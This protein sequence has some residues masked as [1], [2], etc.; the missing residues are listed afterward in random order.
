LPSSQT[1]WSPFRHRV[2]AVLWVATLLSNVGTWMHEVGAGWLMTTM[3]T[4]PIWVALVQTTSTLPVF[5]LALP[6]GALAD[7]LDRRRLLLATQVTM[8]LLAAALGGTVLAGAMMPLT[9][10]LFTFALGMCTALISPAWQAIVPG[11]VPKSDLASA[12]ALNSAGFNVSRAIGPALAGAIIVAFGLA[13]PFLVNALSFLVVIA[14]LIWWRPAPAPPKVLPSEQFYAAIRSG[15]RYTRSSDPLKSTMLR[16]FLFLVFASAYWALIPLVARERLGGAASLYGLLV[17]CIGAGAVVGAILLPPVRVRLGASRL[18]AI[19]TVLTA[20]VLLVF[21]LARQPWIAAVASF[22]AGAAWLA[23]LSTFHISAQTSLP[24]WVRARGL[25]I[26]T[27]VFYGSLAGGSLLWGQLASHIGVPGALMAAAAGAVLCLWPTTRLS[28]QSGDTLDLSPAANW[29]QPVVALDMK[30]DAGPVMVTVEYRVSRDQVAPF[31]Q[32][33]KAQ[34]KARRRNGAFGW[35]IFQDTGEP[36]RFLEYFLQDS[37][38]AH[39]RHHER[40]TEDDRRLQAR[41]ASFHH[42]PE[43]PRVRHFLAAGKAVATLP[44]GDDLSTEY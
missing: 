11:L 34:A 15:L 20:V 9:L 36:E 3:T 30:H 18:V 41:I 42:G 2:F 29:P 6:A 33:M 13:W 35:G 44:R 4:S 16:A 40:V 38:L 19:S 7:I 28:L 17:G 32:A 27:A 5:L 31:L 14:A 43:P 10:L 1:I 25:S 39:L 8:M 12:I 37:W 22:V 26:Y 21:A 24:D 23:A